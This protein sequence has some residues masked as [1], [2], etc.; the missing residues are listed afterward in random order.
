MHCDTILLLFSIYLHVITSQIESKLKL[1]E[2]EDSIRYNPSAYI[3]YG[4]LYTFHLR[5]CKLVLFNKGINNFH[6]NIK[7]N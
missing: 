2:T 7:F 4:V 5:T 6:K 3:N 1:R